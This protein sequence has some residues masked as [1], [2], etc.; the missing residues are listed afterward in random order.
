MNEFLFICLTVVALSLVLVALRL[1]EHWLYGLVATFLLIAN[2]F[3]SKLSIVFGVVSSLS[4]PIYAAIFLA[5]DAAAEH[6]GKRFAYRLVWVGFG[7]QVS[8][9]AFGQLIVR[10]SAFG[11]PTVADALSTVFG[12]IPRIAL[13]SFVAYIISQNFDVRLF[14]FLKSRFGGK[15]LWLRNCVS[16]ITSQGIDSAIFL[17]IAFYG[18]L[19]NLGEFFVSVWIVKICVALFDT[20]FLYLSRRVVGNGASPQQ[21]EVSGSVIPSNGGG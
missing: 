8:L 6:F 10:G 5:T 12:F 7:A 16:T 20:P 17:L 9:V 21:L 2:L 13:G 3:A 19:P 1:G 14:D 15:H 4:I 18:K 11:D